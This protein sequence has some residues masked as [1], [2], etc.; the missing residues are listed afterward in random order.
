MSVIGLLSTL[1]SFGDQRKYS[2]LEE[3][4]ANCCCA[5]QQWRLRGLVGSVL[6]HRSLPPEFESRRFGDS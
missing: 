6:D 4:E 3:S 1:A 5:Q 2:D